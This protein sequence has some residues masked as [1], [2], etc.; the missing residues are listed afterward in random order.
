[1][2][3]RRVKRLPLS[4]WI[5]LLTWLL[6]NLSSFRAGS[7]IFSESKLSHFLRNCRTFHV[8]RSAATYEFH[9]RIK[10]M[11]DCFRLWSWIISNAADPLFCFRICSRVHLFIRQMRHF[12][13]PIVSIVLNSKSA[14]FLRIDGL[15][16]SDADRSGSLQKFY[17][18]ILILWRTAHYLLSLGLDEAWKHDLSLLANKLCLL[19]TTCLLFR[20]NYGAQ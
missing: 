7:I 12:P 15:I 9:S 13:L 8:L 6:G 14:T 19:L 3:F 20:I 17:W 16:A 4:C 2:G 5:V 1:M 11:N 10:K 18:K